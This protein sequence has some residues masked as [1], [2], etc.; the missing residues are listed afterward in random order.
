MSVEVYYNNKKEEICALLSR[1]ISWF[2]Y[3]NWQVETSPKVICNYFRESAL[4]ELFKLFILNLE[5]LLNFT[6]IL[7]NKPFNC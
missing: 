2:N 5:N 1:E 7:S 3:Q 4:L 6:I